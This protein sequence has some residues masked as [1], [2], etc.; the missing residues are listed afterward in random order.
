MS[1]Q[2]FNTLNYTLANED[3]TLEFA[4]VK[5]EASEKVFS[6]AGSGARFIPL[7]QD[8]VKELYYID[9]C[10]EQLWLS[11]LR[12]ATYR[13]FTY[14]EFLK[15]WGYAPFATESFHEF[16]K[17]LFYRLSLRAE[18]KEYFQKLFDQYSWKALLYEGKWE[19]T[20]QTLYK[21]NRFLVG[22]D[23]G[24]IFFSP[25]IQAQQSYFETKFPKLRWSF[26][27]ALLGNKKVFDALLYK[28]HF[29]KKNIPDSYF[30]YYKKAFDHLFQKTLVRESFFMNLCFFGKI[31]FP[32]GNPI[33]AQECVFKEVKKNLGG[34]SFSLEGINKNLIEAA[35]SLA[36][37]EIDFVSLSD[38]PSY[39]SG[40][41]EKTF[42]QSLKPMLKKGAVVVVRY[43]L[44]IAQ[45]DETG[46][47][48]IT[49][50]YAEQIAQ[51]KVQMYRVKILRFKF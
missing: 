37:K 46:F 32:E 38:V 20:F 27:I 51:E 43:Y 45:V 4:I 2:Y 30:S 14:E 3:T 15:F 50:E 39:F 22:K 28:G 23:L 34:P 21:I 47:E 36:G 48:D 1:Q 25:T 33:D 26:V 11:E 17:G 7:I 18:V 35:Q 42:L 31:M 6:I 41:L 5:R 12:L 44:R 8:H 13:H 9:M 40:P 49:H 29:V 10:Q 19:K 16:R 24:K